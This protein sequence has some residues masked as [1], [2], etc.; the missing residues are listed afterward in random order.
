MEDVKPEAPGRS[1][2]YR[3]T[4]SMRQC[5]HL[6]PLTPRARPNSLITTN[7]TVR[8][9]TR[10]HMKRLP[11]S[12]DTSALKT[13][14]QGASS[15]I[16]PTKALQKPVL[17]A[18]KERY[19]D[20]DEYSVYADAGTPWGTA[21]PSPTLYDSD[22]DDVLAPAWASPAGQR[23]PSN[24]PAPG[25]SCNLLMLSA[26]AGFL[27]DFSKPAPSRKDA[28][29]TACNGIK[30]KLPPV[31]G[32]AVV[33]RLNNDRE[34]LTKVLALLPSRSPPLVTSALSR[35]VVS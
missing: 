29:N 18:K 24:S 8:H 5:A 31:T 4:R 11:T 21:P 12:T 1:R 15:R 9:F 3:V 7:D 34:C 22:A 10:A 2:G 19:S 14:R 27:L 23:V 6:R 33:S 26:L 17:R 13:T 32:E 35:L 30:A 20:Q 16:P 25:T 28:W